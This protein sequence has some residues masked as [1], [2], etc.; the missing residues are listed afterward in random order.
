MSDLGED[1]ALF[2]FVLLIIESTASLYFILAKG[3]SL[4]EDDPNSST[5]FKL[6][7]K[8]APKRWVVFDRWFFRVFFSALGLVLL[9]EFF[10]AKP[11]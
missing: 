4:F 7:K 10:R 3:G 1:F 5:F 11:N 2:L 8:Y 9:I 6:T